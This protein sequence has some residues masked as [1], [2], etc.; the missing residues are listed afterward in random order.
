MPSNCDPFTSVT[1]WYGPIGKRQKLVVRLTQVFKARYCEQL[2]SFLTQVYDAS[3]VDAMASVIEPAM[4]DDPVVS[5]DKWRSEVTR[6]RDYMTKHATDMA[7]VV[8][9]ACADAL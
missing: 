5:E 4:V 7:A 8:G 3:K 9:K 6:M 1:N 2:H